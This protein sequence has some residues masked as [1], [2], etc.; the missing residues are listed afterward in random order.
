MYCAN[1]GYQLSAEAKFCSKCG[2]KV[3]PKQSE[4]TAK[5]DIKTVKGTATGIVA[6]EDAL[7]QGIKAN[8][9]QTVETVESG[10]TVAGM[11]F[12]GDE[13]QT[14]VGGRH[15]HGD[16]VEGNK[17]TGGV[18]IGRVG[19]DIRDSVIAGRDV[20]QN[21][22][23]FDQRGQQVGTQY[24]AAGDMAI[25]SGD[26]VSGDKVGGD[27]VGGDQITVGHISGSSG[28]AIGRGASATVNQGLD[29]AAIAQ[30]F[31]PVYQKIATLPDDPDGDKVELTETV[32]KIE[33][34]V[35]KGEAAN[36][37]RVE[38]WLRNIALM[39]EDIFDVATATLLSPVA[40]IATIIKK[41]AAKAREDK[42][43]KK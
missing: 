24:N 31:A 38:R 30:L 15:Q 43:V 16:T 34:E 11:V 39:S 7:D 2:H 37:N 20:T 33:Q 10:G 40:G 6:G 19:G 13:G 25:Q 23:V 9:E 21:R 18:S 26:I 3:S 41:V 22:S 17:V 1:C 27:K 5:Q 8:T 42:G 35:A 36:P 32:Q 12:G 28:V 29:A 14:Y 4:I